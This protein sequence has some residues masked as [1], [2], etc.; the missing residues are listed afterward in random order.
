[1]NRSSRSSNKNLNNRFQAT[2]N[3]D[4]SETDVLD[5]F[6]GCVNIL[7]IFCAVIYGAVEGYKDD[8]LGSAI[9]VA[10]VSG[11]AAAIAGTFVLGAIGVI[12][13]ALKKQK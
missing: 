12:Y 10:I 9:V 3:R 2:T 7:F 8:G 5:D 6:L 11:V 4:S 13:E 1:M